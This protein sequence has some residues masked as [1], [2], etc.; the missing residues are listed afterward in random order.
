MG[1]L[2]ILAETQAQGVV[3]II[4]DLK[5][6]IMLPF[7]PRKIGA[8]LRC[9]ICNFNLLRIHHVFIISM[10]NIVFVLCSCNSYIS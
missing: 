8:K 6:I 1:T 3:T 5:H 4:I 7:F 2:Y 10:L 9:D